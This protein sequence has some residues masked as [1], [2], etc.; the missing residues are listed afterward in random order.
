MKAAAEAA[1]IAGPYRIELGSLDA[2]RALEAECSRLGYTRYLRTAMLP[3]EEAISNKM[4]IAGV[5]VTWPER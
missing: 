3:R 4:L 2:G 1:G 5:A